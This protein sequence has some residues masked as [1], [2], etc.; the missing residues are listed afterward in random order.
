MNIKVTLASSVLF[1][2]LI[3]ACNEIQNNKADKPNVIIVFIDDEGY[4]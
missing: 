4:W 2:V 3:T 1:L